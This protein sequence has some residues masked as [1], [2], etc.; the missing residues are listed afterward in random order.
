MRTPAAGYFYSLK[1]PQRLATNKPIASVAIKRVALRERT[2]LELNI[3]LLALDLRFY[4]SCSILHL[5][6][7]FFNASRE[8]K[9]CKLYYITIFLFV[10]GLLDTNVYK[11]GAGARILWTLY[12][13][14]CRTTAT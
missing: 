13:A 7:D 11:I 10:W 8:L 14:A 2:L 3:Y 12:A 1:I 5:K 6:T 4:R 9:S